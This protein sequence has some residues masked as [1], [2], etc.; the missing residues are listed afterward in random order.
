[1][2]TDRKSAQL[3][4][5][6]SRAEKAAIQR[7]AKGAGMPMSAYVLSRVLSIPANRFQEWVAAAAGSKPSF[8]LAELN[9]MLTEASAAELRDAVAASPRT[10]LSPYLANYIAAMVELACSRRAIS[11]PAW[12]RAIEPLREPSFGS[13][14]PN[15]RHY[16]LTRSPAPFRCRNIFIDSTLGSRV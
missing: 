8:G 5:R 14:L 13:S 1:M 9:K 2:P 11:V 6:V 10:P 16:L 12:A 7:A 4:I 3:Q 15:L